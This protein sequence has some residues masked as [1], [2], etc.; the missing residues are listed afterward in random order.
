MGIA[1]G[2]STQRE[3]AAMNITPMIDVLLVLLMIFIIPHMKTIGTFDIQ[4]P[5]DPAQDD[6]IPIC[7]PVLTPESPGSITMK[8]ERHRVKVAGKPVEP[9]Q[10]G[11]FLR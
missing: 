4:L 10:L 6:G 11:A 8:I 7:G 3:F 1:T 2:G 9:A 5:R